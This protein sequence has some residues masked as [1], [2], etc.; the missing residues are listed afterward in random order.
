MVMLVVGSASVMSLAVLSSNIL[1]ASASAGE[2]SVLQADAMA[3]SG[4]NRA[5]YYLQN[6]DSTTKCP[7]TVASGGTYTEN[8]TTLGSSVPGSFNLQVKGTGTNRWKI[9][10][11]GSVTT[12]RGTITRKLSTT[13]DVNYFGYAV[14][15]GSSGA[16][17]IPASVTVTG[18]VYAPGAVTNAGALGGTLYSSSATNSGSGS[19]RA[20]KSSSGV[21]V[22]PVPAL[23]SA[24][25]YGMAY[26]YNGKAG[27]ATAL[28]LTTLSNVT[29]GPTL[30]NPAGIYTAIGNL[31]LNGNAKINGV[32]VI[33]GG[34]LIVKNTGNSITAPTGLAAVISDGDLVFKADSATLDVSGL[35]WV[36]TKIS[37]NA[38]TGAGCRLAVT[39]AFISPSASPFDSG[40][41]T[42]IIYDKAKASVPGIWLGLTRPPAP[43]N[44]TVVGWTN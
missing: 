6:I 28:V 27:L 36:A 15:L 32:L 44:L 8:G 23:A 24:N 26:T 14:A 38:T 40:V 42:T 9:D 20:S 43:T 10:S 13:I 2:G 11:T 12:T 1:Q 5:L 41:P 37:R 19:T 21:T 33:N 39:G 34:Q 18:D 22:T 16:T 35:V 3:E 17:S 4:I 25:H 31:T 29:Y 30:A 7:A